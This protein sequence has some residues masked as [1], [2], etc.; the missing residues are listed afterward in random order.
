MQGLRL[1][2]LEWNRWVIHRVCPELFQILRTVLQN[3]EGSH[4][5]ASLPALG[6]TQLSNTSRPAMRETPW[7]KPLL[8]TR[9]ELCLF[10]VCLASTSL[11]NVEAN[12]TQ[13]Q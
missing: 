7:L 5:P 13:S 1:R 3:G 10:V 8:S 11:T 4:I 2:T 12:K 9:L 6:I